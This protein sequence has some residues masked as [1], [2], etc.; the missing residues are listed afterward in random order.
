MSA[1]KVKMREKKLRNQPASVQYASSS[2]QN[3]GDTP[4]TGTDT[5]VC[6]S[7]KASLYVPSS[8]FISTTSSPLAAAWSASPYVSV[9]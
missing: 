9:T 6:L 5:P 8:L 4:A 2:T 1:A 7:V 3:G